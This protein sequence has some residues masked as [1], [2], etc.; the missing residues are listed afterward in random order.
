MGNNWFKKIRIKNCTR[1]YFNSIV[2]LEDFDLGNI[3][4]GKKS[5][6]NILIYEI[7]YKT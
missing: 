2:K 5:H 3:L 6:R 7:S 1:Y 4:L